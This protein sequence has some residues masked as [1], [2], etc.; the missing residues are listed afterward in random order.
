MYC[1]D[2]VLLNMNHNDICVPRLDRNDAI[3]WLSDIAGFSNADGGTMYIGVADKTNKL[4]GF[5]KEE[6]DGEKNYINNQLNEHLFPRPFVKI[7][8]LPYEINNNTRYI[9]KVNIPSVA[10]KPVIVN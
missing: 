10:F 1:I 4:I 2:E 8:F 6:L 3:G 9:I 5:S 7:S